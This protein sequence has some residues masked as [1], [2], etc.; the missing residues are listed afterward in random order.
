M[1][2][3]A[4]LWADF[5]NDQSNQ[6]LRN[7]LIE[8]YLRLVEYH[9]KRMWLKLSSQV[10]LRDLVSAGIF[11][12]IDAI[13]A[14]EVSRGIRFETYCALRVRGAMLDEI[15]NMDWVPRLV[16]SKAGKLDAARSDAQAEHGRPPTDDEIASKL[17]LPGEDFEK[18]KLEAADPGVISLNRTRF[19]TD[20]FKAVAEIDV[21]SDR[22]CEDPA[23]SEQRRDLLKLVSKGLNRNERLIVILYYYEDLTMKE[24]GQQIGLSES[25]VSQMHSSIV[26][27]MQEHL[28]HRRSEFALN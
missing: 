13:E 5:K 26:E 2:E 11:G 27:R 19:E 8:H 6:V 1:A 10:D 3:V 14:F 12:L 4:Q 15:R 23:L 25:R 20:S 22:K 24:I 9:A 17:G 16:R 18:L 21:I 7:R 28:A